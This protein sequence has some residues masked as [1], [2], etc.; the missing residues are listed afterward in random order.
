MQQCKLQLKYFTVHGNKCRAQ[1]LNSCLEDARD[2][3]D[4]EAEARTLQIIRRERDK[5][6][7]NWLNWSL[8]K[9][10]GASVSGVQ[11]VDTNGETVE[12]KS[13]E[14]VQEA[15]W[16]EVHQSRYHLAEEAP[17]C[18]GNLRWEFGYNDDTQAARQ[19]LSGTYKFSPTFHTTTRR[20]MESIA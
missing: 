15:I 7:W 20:L 13:Q 3:G 17:I 4:E 19:I 9:R 1:H 16:K 18:Q 5:R 12:L 6:F 11:I 8:G 14:E 2:K 10:R